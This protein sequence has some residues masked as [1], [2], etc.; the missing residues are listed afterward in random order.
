[1][2]NR[3]ELLRSFVL[4]ALPGPHRVCA[5][6]EDTL[7]GLLALALVHAGQVESALA[8]SAALQRDGAGTQS[9]QPDEETHR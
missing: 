9:H 7:L 6:A 8:A 1:L 5:E 4:A 2:A 3:L